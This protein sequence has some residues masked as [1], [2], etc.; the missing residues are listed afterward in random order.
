MEF[1]Q[2]GLQRDSSIS[3]V[4]LAQLQR[5]SL[6]HLGGV[7]RRE[8]ASGGCLAYH[9]VNQVAASGIAPGESGGMNIKCLPRREAGCRSRGCNKRRGITREPTCGHPSVTRWWPGGGATLDR[10]VKPSQ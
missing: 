8:G 2:C 3:K 10:R 9:L 6:A 7:A 5:N 4:L 1:Q